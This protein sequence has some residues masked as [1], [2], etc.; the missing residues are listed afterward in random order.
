M[1]ASEAPSMIDNVMTQSYPDDYIYAPV[2]SEVNTDPYYSV[3]DGNPSGNIDGVPMLLSATES[4][5]G[6][7][8]SGTSCPIVTESIGSPPGNIDAR[9]KNDDFDY[10]DPLLAELLDRN[11]D[12]TIVGQNKDC[13]AQLDVLE[14]TNQTLKSTPTT[15]TLMMPHLMPLIKLFV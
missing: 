6:L 1:F 15:R 8:S 5:R 12:F 2:V 10:N 13:R 9:E 3:L 11:W 7:C 14:R 4:G